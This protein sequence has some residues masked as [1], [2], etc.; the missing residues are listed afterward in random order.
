MRY[1]FLTYDVFASERFGGNPLAILPDA[2]GLDTVQM[3]DIARE[4]NLSETTFVTSSERGFGPR[5]RIF[6]P[7]A[8]LPFAGHP[9]V[10]TAIALAD[11]GRVDDR[12]V[13]LEE[14]AGPVEVVLDAA[15]MA[16][17]R[18]PQPFRLGEQ[19]TRADAML[20][21]GLEAGAIVA[22]PC[23]AG[24]GLPFPIIEV[25]DLEVLASASFRGMANGHPLRCEAFVFTR[26]TDGLD[27]DLRARLFAPGFG[28]PED[29]ATGSAAGALAGLLAHQRPE[30]DGSWCWRLGQGVEMGRPSVIEMRAI[31]SAGRVTDVYVKGGAV[32]VMEGHISV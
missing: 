25:S 14:T 7:R 13:V 3:Q 20:A 8:E 5:V 32:Q 30:V 12:R 27:V 31:K 4:F 28:V 16:E 24:V 19:L 15:G 11:L 22:A 9:T 26:R 17:F 10:G 1:R 6:T 29:P 23:F 18:A 21:L 2:D